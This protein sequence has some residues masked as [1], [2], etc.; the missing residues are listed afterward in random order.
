[1]KYQPQA[2]LVLSSHQ[3]GQS[4]D[5][6]NPYFVNMNRNKRSIAVDLRTDQGKAIIRRL[7]KRADVLIE[8]YRPGIME[9]MGLGYEDLKKINPGLIY[10]AISGFAGMGRAG[11]C[12]IV[13]P[14][15]AASRR[16]ARLRGSARAGVTGAVTG[17]A[18]D[19]RRRRVQPAG[20]GARPRPARPAGSQHD[21][22][23][24]SSPD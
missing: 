12:A 22:S 9:K 13:S 11:A 6:E 20:P 18:S 1:M 14:G 16:K 17:R 23:G 3:Q 19:C 7:I 24:P 15:P 4:G 10:A 5:G 21:R 8:N 2:C